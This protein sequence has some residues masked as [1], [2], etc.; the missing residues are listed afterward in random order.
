MSGLPSLLMSSRTISS[1]GVVDFNAVFSARVAAGTQRQLRFELLH[2]LAQLRRGRELPID[3]LRQVLRFRVQGADGLVELRQPLAHVDKAA[4][5]VLTSVFALVVLLTLER[6]TE[7]GKTV[8]L[9]HWGKFTP[10]IPRNEKSGKVYF[11]RTNV[12]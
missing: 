2:F 9:T 8:L 6:K 3:G 7:K 5:A 11:E 12:K 4:G 10:V 1:E